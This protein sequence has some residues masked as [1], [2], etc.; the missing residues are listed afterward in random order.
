MPTG[1]NLR[2]M[3]VILH[4]DRP[5]MALRIWTDV[6][7]PVPL[8]PHCLGVEWAGRLGHPSSYALLAGSLLPQSSSRAGQTKVKNTLAGRLDS[9]RTGLLPEYRE[10]V[11]SA[12]GDRLRITAA[13]H[14]DV[15]SSRAVFSSLA[16]LL[17]Y[18]LESGVPDSEEVLWQRWD[19]ASGD[20]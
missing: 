15:G 14:G 19:E 12:A 17:L 18:L 16:T 20:G 3:D 5:H 2:I 4:R 8:P 9:V 11:R 6:E 1:S 7:G 13:A 10:A